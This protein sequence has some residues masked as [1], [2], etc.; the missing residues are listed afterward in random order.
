M[1]HTVYTERKRRRPVI[2]LLLLPLLAFVWLIGWSLTWVGHPTRVEKLKKPDSI[3]TLIGGS[4]E[5]KPQT[6][7]ETCDARD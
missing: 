2:V 5:E 1:V 4:D 3:I 7:Q 6:P